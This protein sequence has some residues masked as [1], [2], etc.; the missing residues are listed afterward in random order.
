MLRNAGGFTENSFAY[1]AVNMKASCSKLPTE[2]YLILAV[3][4]QNCCLVVVINV[5]ASKLVA[6]GCFVLFFILDYHRSVRPRPTAQVA[7]HLQQAC[8]VA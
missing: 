1:L 2:R 4:C 8:S 6:A 7:Q 5:V 3:I